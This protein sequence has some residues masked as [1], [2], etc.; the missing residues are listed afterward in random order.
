MVI[1]PPSLTPMATM[2]LGE[3]IH[4]AGFPKGVFNMVSGT[5]ATIGTELVRNPITKMVSLTGSGPAYLS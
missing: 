2:K 3:L 1:K 5:G 4:E